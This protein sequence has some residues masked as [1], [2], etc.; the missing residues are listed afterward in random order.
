MN[1]KTLEKHPHEVFKV[2]DDAAASALLI[3][4]ELLGHFEKQGLAT[5]SLAAAIEK[6]HATHWIVGLKFHGFARE[7]DNGYA[8]LALPKSSFG[9]ADAFAQVSKLSAAVEGTL[10]WSGPLPEAG[11][12]TGN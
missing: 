3:E 11:P 12:S 1:A 7:S 8:V 10:M 4:L 2:M 6:E 9:M 5:C